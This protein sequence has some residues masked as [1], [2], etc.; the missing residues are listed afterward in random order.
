LL[1]YPVS[2]QRAGL[3]YQFVLIVEKEAVYRRFALV[4]TE[5][6][7]HNHAGKVKEKLRFQK[8]LPYILL[9]KRVM[10]VLCWMKQ[11]INPVCL[12]PLFS[13]NLAVLGT[14]G[15]RVGTAK[16]ST[17]NFTPTRQTVWAAQVIEWVCLLTLYFTLP[18]IPSSRQSFL[19]G[20][21]LFEEAHTTN[22]Y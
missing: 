19:P 20:A 17:F 12:Q 10:K 21:D 1:G 9:E 13:K 18:A 22:L 7:T 3:H 4:P 2:F 15:S 6:R 14:A 11:T 16:P 5:P 8:H